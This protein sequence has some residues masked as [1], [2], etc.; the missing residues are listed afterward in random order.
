MNKRLK[1]CPVCNSNLEIVEYHCPNCDTSIKGKFGIGDLSLLSPVQQEFAKTFLC[2]SG[3]IKEVEKAMNISYPTVKNKLAEIISVLCSKEKPVT[4]VSSHDILD[5]ID[6]GNLS[7][8][9]ALSKLR[10]RS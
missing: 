3:N 10:D 5:E 1:Q 6:K 2:C 4:D 9:E 7:V 8:K